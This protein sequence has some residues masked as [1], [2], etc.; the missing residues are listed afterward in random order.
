MKKSSTLFA[1]LGVLAKGP[2]AGY[3]IRK[4]F[5]GSLRYFWSES[6]GQ[7][8]PTLK[9]IVEMG[10]AVMEEMPSGSR[11]RKVYRLTPEGETRFREWLAEPVA[12]LTYRDELLLKVYFSGSEHK[13]EIKA[14]FQ[15]EAAMLEETLALYRAQEQEIGAHFEGE[16]TPYWQLTLRYGVLSTEA[17]LQWCRE[18]IAW[19]DRKKG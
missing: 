7:I 19:L 17:R 18:S 14:L 15:A 10:L 4:Q 2:A 11:T 1:V 5:S 6:Y 3:D 13:K 9:E 16:E 12:P 8:Y